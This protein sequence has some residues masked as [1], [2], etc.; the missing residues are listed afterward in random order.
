MC[1]S[2][3]LKQCSPQ[4][5]GVP[6]KQSEKFKFLGIS[7]TSDGRQNIEL[8]KS[9]CSNAPAPPICGNET[10]VLHQGKAVHRQISLRGLW[11]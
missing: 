10:R 5:G 1:L 6:L 7:F 11:P 8:S 3:Q 9:K 4:V 2:R